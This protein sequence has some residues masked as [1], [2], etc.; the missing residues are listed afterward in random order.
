VL[1]ASRDRYWCDYAYH[2]API[3]AS[4]V[5]EMEWL[6]TQQGV[7]SFK[8]FMFY[9]GHGLHGQADR[10]AQ[11][12][13]LMVGEDESY[14]IRQAHPE[15]APH[16][17]VSLHCEIADI[18]NAYTQR[19]AR[20]GS[21]AGLR[22]YSAARPPHAEGLAV[23]IAGYLAHETGCPGINLLHLS[24]R[25]AVEAA[26]ALPRVFPAHPAAR[27][28]GVP[29]AGAARAEARL[30]GERPCL[31]RPR[32]EGGRG[33][34]GRHLAGAL[35]LRRNRVPPGGRCQRGQPARDG[36]LPHGGGARGALVYD[37][38]RVMGPAR[39]RS[40]SRPG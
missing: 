27:G 3:Q 19:V 31:L 36:V 16:V 7:P 21:L 18:L 30:G 9:G 40:L 29:L 32:D 25:K 35:R 17:S 20:D 24:S 11:R 1:A 12:R 26:L 38:R 37:G 23:W 8:I 14:D 4:H 34:P 15:L 39:G 10:A 13:F 2:L 5:D 6:A 33:A 28:R 22:A